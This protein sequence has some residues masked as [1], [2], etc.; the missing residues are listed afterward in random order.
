MFRAVVGFCSRGAEWEKRGGV[1]GRSGVVVVVMA[2]VVVVV[3]VVT[4][5]VGLSSRGGPIRASRMVVCSFWADSQAA[6]GRLEIHNLMFSPFFVGFSSC[7]PRF[8]IRN[9]TFLT[10]LLVR[11]LELWGPDS[12]FKIRLFGAFFGWV[13]RGPSPWRHPRRWSPPLWK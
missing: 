6:G 2:V 12:S 7:G 9:L 13:E 1:S 3:G 4:F 8:E 10:T 11:I 5:F